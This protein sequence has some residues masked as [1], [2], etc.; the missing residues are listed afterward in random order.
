MTVHYKAHLFQQIAAS[1]G[2]D[3]KIM[4]IESHQKKSE[5]LLYSMLPR[6][7]ADRLKRGEK[8]LDTCQ[9]TN[10]L[11]P[12]LARSASHFYNNNNNNNNN[13]FIVLNPKEFRGLLK[14]P[15]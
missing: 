1:K 9:V 2:I 6:P 8:A 12:K 11:L 4:K 13:M 10:S 3:E 7:V 14:Y 5:D 15:R